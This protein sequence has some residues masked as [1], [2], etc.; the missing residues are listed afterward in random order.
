MLAAPSDTSPAH[1]ELGSELGDIYVVSLQQF[2]QHEL[3]HH[4]DEGSE[5]FG[6]AMQTAAG[7][8]YHHGI[9]ML[10]AHGANP[11]VLSLEEGGL[12]ALQ[13]A[14]AEGYNHIVQT[15]LS[16]GANVNAP[17]AGSMAHENWIEIG[18]QPR[19]QKEH[20]P[21]GRTALQAAAEGGHVAVVKTL[22]KSG[23]NVNARPG[24]CGGRTAL[25]AA[26]G[27]GHQV[28]L[29]MLLSE[30]AD[31]NAPP[32][33]KGRTALQAAAEGGHLAVVGMLLERGADVNAP[34]S[35]GALHAAATNGHQ[36]VVEALL[37][38]GA[39]IHAVGT[40]E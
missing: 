10:L 20:W 36:L 24:V 19:P 25:Q 14:A 37:R 32:A 38:S 1:F 26:A 3:I 9:T 11:N 16:N 34:G 30:G 40:H 23:A 15:L 33:S 21:R 28:V 17:A 27:G 5:R 39:N 8:G 22:L 2:I 31:V 7:C 6:L 35:F 12:N 29:E 18:P 13:I 4:P